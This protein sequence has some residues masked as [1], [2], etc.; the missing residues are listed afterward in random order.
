MPPL[1]LLTCY[2]AIRRPRFPV[3]AGF[4]FYSRC[5]ASPV[6]F[7]RCAL[8]LYTLR[9]SPEEL[10]HPLLVP[11][12]QPPT[13]MDATMGHS[14]ERGNHAM[15]HPPPPPPP[16]QKTWQA[17]AKAVMTVESSL[18]HAEP[19]LKLLGVKCI[20]RSIFSLNGAIPCMH[21]LH[22]T[23]PTPWQSEQT[24]AH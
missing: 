11:A 2:V 20:Q 1:D 4:G 9:T 15:S 22:K 6:C 3:T 8:R 10:K 24:T 23:L 21:S 13:F 14:T 19:T 18:Y 16:H 12:R 17:Y 7:S 5:T